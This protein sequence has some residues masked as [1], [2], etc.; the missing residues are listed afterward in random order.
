MSAGIPTPVV[1]A[2]M[3]GASGGA[4]AAQTSSAGA[5]GFI[6]AGYLTPSRI[7]E[8][9]ALARAQLHIS[10]TD[11][12][13]IGVGYLAWQLEK[14]LSSAT[15]LL[16]AALS[17]RVQA[18]WLA[19]GNNIGRWIEYVRSYDAISGRNQRTLIFVQV[20]SVEEARTAIQDWK[21]D[22]LIA[23]GFF[24]KSP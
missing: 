18:I 23:Q 1:A 8:E 22:V 9:V 14:D 17:N 21:V 11:P 3:A 15:D 12:L 2:P 19:F 20:S 7:Q 5:F 4:L 13:P 24:P 16:N 6:G 10:E